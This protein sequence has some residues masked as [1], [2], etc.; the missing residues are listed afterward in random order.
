MNKY[1]IYNFAGANKETKII[2]A[3]SIADAEATIKEINPNF[4]FSKVTVLYKNVPVV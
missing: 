2:V 1:N 3:K 4:E